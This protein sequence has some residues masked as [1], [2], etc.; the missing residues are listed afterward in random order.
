[1]TRVVPLDDVVAEAWSYVETNGTALTAGSLGPVECDPDQL[2]RLFENLFRNA[3]EHGH[4][5]TLTVERFDDGGFAVEDDGGGFDATT[6]D[7]FEKGH[8]S[9]NGGIGF[10]LTIVA[11]IAAAHDWTVDA[12]TGRAGGARFEVRPS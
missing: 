7:L 11:D 9:A 10:G 5:D 12:T 6:D 8:R 2:G 3:V 4:A 1:D